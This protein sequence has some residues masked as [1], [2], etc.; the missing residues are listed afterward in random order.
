M[1]DD[2]LVEEPVSVESGATQVVIWLLTDQG[3]VHGCE[4]ECPEFATRKLSRV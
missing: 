4:D 1:L 2:E 3:F